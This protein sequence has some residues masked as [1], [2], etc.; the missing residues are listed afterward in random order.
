MTVRAI[1]RKG[2]VIP[3]EPLPFA[4]GTEVV[5][6]VSAKRAAKSPRPKGASA[7]LLKHAG[8]VDNLPSDLSVNH[9]HYLYGVP[10]KK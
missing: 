5:I 8:G 9:D 4:D 1:I 2:K 7:F 10:K 6:D 3:T